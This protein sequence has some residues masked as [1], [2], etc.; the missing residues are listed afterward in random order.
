MK[1]GCDAYAIPG[2]ERILDVGR[3]AVFWFFNVLLLD[4]LCLVPAILP[5]TDDRELEFGLRDIFIAE[6]EVLVSA[7][8]FFS[9]T[10]IQNVHG[11]WRG[12]S[13][14]LLEIKL[15][16][17]PW[18]G[19]WFVQVHFSVVVTWLLLDGWKFFQQR[20]GRFAFFCDL[21]TKNFQLPRSGRQLTT[22]IIPH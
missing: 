21:F 12:R 22:F 14:F 9:K 1:L 17:G 13:H 5:G 8:A 6:L 19:W 11:T 15:R 4:F 20:F 3:T 2:I 7:F 18:H 16:Q 10:I